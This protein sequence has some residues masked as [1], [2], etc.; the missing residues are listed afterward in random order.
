M[1]VTGQ[2]PASKGDQLVRSIPFP[3]R[4]RRPVD[5][6]APSATVAPPRTPSWPG[7]PAD[8]WTPLRLAPEDPTLLS[9]YA[10]G[11]MS[12]ER[13]SQ[14]RILDASRAEHERFLRAAADALAFEAAVAEATL[15]VHPDDVAAAAYLGLMRAA[16]PVVSDRALPAA[17]TR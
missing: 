10:E 3:R 11:G 2:A 5:D 15:I 7:N 6:F 13:Q 16:L 1:P 12:A 8:D 4:H 14:C 9:G 17:V